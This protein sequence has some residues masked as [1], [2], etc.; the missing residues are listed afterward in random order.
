MLYETFRRRSRRLRKII[1]NAPRATEARAA[2]QRI[3]LSMVTVRGMGGKLKACD[4]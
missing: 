4:V 2:T 3:L 1:L